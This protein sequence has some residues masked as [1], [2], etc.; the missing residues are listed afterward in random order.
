ML[1]FANP[2][3]KNERSSKRANTAVATITV[4]ETKAK[5]P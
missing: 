3:Q 2:S 4:V 5:P 1:D